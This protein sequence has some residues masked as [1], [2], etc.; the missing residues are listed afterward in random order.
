MSRPLRIEY[1]GA[2]YH[3]TSRGNE[4]KDIFKSTIDRERFL[5]YLET[6]TQRYGAAIHAY[7]L[8]N[9]HYH[10]LLETPLGNLSQI[11]RHINGAYTT[12]INVK[13][14]R[15]GH[16]FQGRYKAILVEADEYA[17]ELSR[18]IHLNPVRAGIVEKPE[19]FIWSSYN[20]YI[21]NK[22]SQKWLSTDFIL[23]YFD[24]KKSS[25]AKNYR[26]FVEGMIDHRYESPLKDVVAS[27][28]LGGKDFVSEI[29]EKYID[30][31]KGDRNLPSLRA[32]PEMRSVKEI[33]GS[34]YRITEGDSKVAKGMSIYI[35]HR[36]SGAKLRVIGDYFGISES[37]VTR[38]S[39][40]F[41]E[42][43]EGDKGLKKLLMKV[44]R[45]LWL[46]N[47]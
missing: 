47:A 20:S 10:I 28:I 24:T 38:A 40:R 41:G 26:Q 21:G 8:M 29:V 45:I 15:A 39:Q 6:S 42:K 33:V 13:R 17:K 7:C 32:L 23:G 12:Y 4:Q 44:E 25:A 11:M 35:C 16:L 3:V 46:S 22:E 30:R 19:E 14:K 18:Y 31:Q 37:G 5:H 9:N 43:V 34:I 1:A 2:Y 27:T 36:Y